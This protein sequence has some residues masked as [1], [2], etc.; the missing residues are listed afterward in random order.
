[1]NGLTA[2]MALDFLELPTGSTIAVIGAA[3][4]VGGYTV[5]L[6]KADGLRVIA[7]AAP[8]DEQLVKDLGADLV[9][10]RG[11]AFPDLVR[12]EIPDGVDGLVDTA[13]VAVDGTRAV[14]EGGR[15]ATSAG[16]SQETA[17]RGISIHQTFVPEYAHDHANLERLHRLVEEGRVT[18]RV[19]R[20]LPAE[21]ARDAHRLGEAGHRGE[22][23]QDDGEGTP[24]DGGTFRR[25]RYLRQR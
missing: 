9:L 10:S 8:K 17:E 5:Q 20:T 16:A 2:R 22:R 21:Q 11:D 6:A 1:M 14:R 23:E 19:A 3:G 24:V 25:H 4:A 12:K 18:L 13:G 7:D 15:V